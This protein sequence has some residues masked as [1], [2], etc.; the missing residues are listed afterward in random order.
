LW[1][2]PSYGLSADEWPT[3]PGTE[4]VKA[5][6]KLRLVASGGEIVADNAPALI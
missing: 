1:E 2:P 4:P 6:P 5:F 3:V